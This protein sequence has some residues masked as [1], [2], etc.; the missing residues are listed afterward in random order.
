MATL[1][2]VDVGTLELWTWEL[3]E[4]ATQSH[5]PKALEGWCSFEVRP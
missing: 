3:D 2:E 5:I 1:R 4:H